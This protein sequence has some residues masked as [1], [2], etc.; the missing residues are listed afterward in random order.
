M[1]WMYILP[2]LLGGLIGLITN[3]IAIK[4]LFY[5]KTPWKLGNFTIPLTPGIV[6]KNRTK[7]TQEIATL[8]E[9]KLFT[10]ADIA[11]ILQTPSFK[12]SLVDAIEEAI[13]QK[14]NHR[15]IPENLVFNLKAFLVKKILTY[16]DQFMEN[17]SQKILESIDIK[18]TIEDKLNELT[19]DEMEN[20]ILSVSGKHLKWITLLGGILGTAIGTLQS[21]IQILQLH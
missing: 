19:L 14:L 10:T 18:K 7:L 21:L 5:P 17:H 6:P 3:H 11:A 20:L 1:F 9:E 2:P 8:V 12:N 13:D 4:M 16:L 15:F